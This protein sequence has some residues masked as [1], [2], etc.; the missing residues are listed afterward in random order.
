[1]TDFIRLKRE[2]EP[3]LEFVGADGTPKHDCGVPPRLLVY[4]PLERRETDYALIEADCAG[5]ILEPGSTEPAC[6]TR[7]RGIAEQVFKTISPDQLNQIA[8]KVDEGVYKLGD[9]DKIKTPD[10]F[11]TLTLIYD[12]TNTDEIILQFLASADK[13]G[14]ITEKQAM[15]EL[16]T[17]LEVSAGLTLE[18]VKNPATL[19]TLAR[20][21]L[22]A[23]D[24]ILQFPGS[25][26]PEALREIPIPSDDV[27]RDKVKE[28]APQEH[29]ETHELIQKRKRALKD[30][31]AWE[32]KVEKRVKV[33]FEGRRAKAGKE[34][35]KSIDDARAGIKK[36]YKEYE[37]ELSDALTECRDQV[38][39]FVEELI[40]KM[41]D[42]QLQGLL[43][44]KAVEVEING[45]KDSVVIPG[46]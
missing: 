18:T 40:P 45:V 12:T 23:A 8:R 9:L 10:N 16:R 13:D 6:N 30:L 25:D 43:D 17:L 32:R 38:D 11:Q 42:D 3:Y 41:D 46:T 26:L 15:E 22:L 33:I 35:D 21:E 34:W 29:A 7:L 2:L 31:I 44:G 37:L 27:H 19:R 36:A 1:M 28:L 24:L 5:V 4:L 39:T 14:L 20:K